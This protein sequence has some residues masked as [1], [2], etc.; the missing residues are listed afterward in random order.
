MTSL[1][2][3]GT[4]SLEN[5][6]VLMATTVRRSLDTITGD[7]YDDVV[8][9]FVKHALKRSGEL[10]LRNVPNLDD[11][12][13][14]V[15]RAG[16]F[17]THVEP[18]I[19]CASPEIDVPT[20]EVHGPSGIGDII[21]TLN[22]I[23]A[24]REREA[25]CR[26]QYVVYNAVGMGAYRAKD[27]LNACGL[28][29][30]IRFHEVQEL[31]LGDVCP[32]ITVPRYNL[33]A[34]PHVDAGKPIHE[35]FP[36]LKCSYDI[37]I[38]IPECSIQQVERRMSGIPYAALYF[39]SVAWNH[40]CTG[41]QSWAA[42]EWAS[43]CIYLL[44]RGITPVVLGADWDAG[45]AD[46]VARE[47]TALG[48]NPPQV[49]INLIGKTPILT[50]LA[51]M[52]CADLNIGSGSSGLTVA[53]AY[54]GMPILT[55]WP[56][57]GVMPIEPSICAAIKDGFSTAWVPPDI[58]RAGNYEVMHFGEFTVTDVQVYID[59]RLND[60]IAARI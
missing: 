22:K 49:W 3:I 12:T 45:Y 33:F 18:G 30:S 9:Q 8:L 42:K 32:D 4:Q 31:P 5:L 35:W 34:N 58:M 57:P 37:A 51:F 39:A 27:F 11:A 59:K 14:C 60:G 21:W 1:A 54:L 46:S 2:L 36:D 38:Q 19:I 40:A 43:V 17:V 13:L 15:E 47:I 56:K 6:E 44:D 26:I 55:F 20:V 16:F 41:G 52:Q 28:I 24:I 29:D 25:P 23:K 50:A 7:T 10:V 48:Y 53:A